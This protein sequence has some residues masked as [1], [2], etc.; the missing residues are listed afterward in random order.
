MK[1]L[2]LTVFFCSAASA[3]VAQPTAEQANYYARP[4][5]VRFGA[6]VG[7]NLSNTD[8]NRG[9]PAPAVPVETS[10]RPGFAAGFTLQVPVGQRGLSVQQEYLFSQL[11]GRV[12][13]TG[14]TYTLRYLS[15][16]LLLK[17]GVSRRLAVLAGPQAD[18]LIQA[19]QQVG[20]TTTDI[21]HDTE[22]RSV[23]AT[24]GLEYFL[25]PRLSV[26]ARYVH[27]LNHVGLGQRSAVTEF[28]FEAVQLSADVKF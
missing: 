3:A 2:L 20:G 11:G 18:L 15:L 5:K 22:E 13:A 7:L 1:Q 23:G 17:Y 27:G 4:T 14:T 28:K 21:T 6:K 25:G 10:W 26:T 16:P 19:N 8:F 12:S 9:F 24:A